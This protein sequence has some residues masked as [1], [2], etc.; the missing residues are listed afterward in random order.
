MYPAK[1]HLVVRGFILYLLFMKVQDVTSV[2][3]VLGIIY[4]PVFDISGYKGY[5]ESVFGTADLQSREFDFDVTDY[6]EAEMGK[7]LLRTFV[8]FERLR[9]P[10]QLAE[11]KR[12]TNVLEKHAGGEKGRVVNLDPGYLDM[13]KCIL[14]SAKYAPQKVYLDKGSTPIP[15]SIIIGDPF[16]PTTG[17]SPISVQGPIMTFLCRCANA[18][19]GS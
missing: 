6:Y 12:L 17:V 19:K 15:R 11:I 1:L 13:D 4:P 18:I 2:K 14:A 8:S 10:S 9:G 3:F 5:L 7:D 16:M